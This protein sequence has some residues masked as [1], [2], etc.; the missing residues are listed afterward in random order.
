MSS[1]SINKKGIVDFLWDWADTNGDW[2][3][4]LVHKI[5]KSEQP[6]NSDERQE[7]F[8]YFLQSVNLKYGMQSLQITKPTY[9]PVGKNIKLKSL[10]NISGVNKLA[11][12]QTLHFGPNITI[13][14]GENGSG[15]TGYSRILRSLGYSYDPGVEILPNVHGTKEEKKADVDFEVDGVVKN[16]IW[17]GTTTDPGLQNLSVF[18]SHCVHFSLS[19]RRLIVSPVG[20]HLFNLVS[21]ELQELQRLFD[22]KKNSYSVDLPWAQNLNAGTPQQ[23]FINTLHARSSEANLVSISS[24]NPSDQQALD[25][26]ISG[27]QSLNKTLL[28]SE[29][30]S[31]NSQRI[32]LENL[33]NTINK[34]SEK[35]TKENWELHKDCINEIKELEKQARLGLTEIAIFQGISLYESSQFRSFIQAAENYIRIL[36]RPDYPSEADKCVYCLQPLDAVAKKLL[37]DYRALMNDKVGEALEQEKKRRAAGIEIFNAAKVLLNVHQTTFGQNLEGVA[38]QPPEILEYNKLVEQ[39]KARFINDDLVKSQWEGLDFELYKKF[40]MQKKN[41]LDEIITDKKK[42]LES[43]GQQEQALRLKIAELT[44]RKLLSSKIE[45]I[46]TAITNHKII[47]IFKDHS[48]AFITTAISRKT[49]EARDALMIQD[50]NDIFQKELKALRKS[51]IKVNLQFGT[52]RGHSKITQRIKTYELAQIL[53]EGEQKAIALAEFLTEI[54]LDNVKAP[55]IFDDPVNSLDHRIIDESVKRLIVLSE[56]RQVIIFTH[57]V[58]FM[59]SMKQQE[60]LPVKKHLNFSYRIVQQN[61]GQTGLLGDFHGLND[62]KYYLSKLNILLNSGTAGKDEGQMSAEGYGHLRSAIEVFVE[63][64]LLGYVVRRYRKGVAFPSLMRLSGDKINA[65]K[66]PLNDIY[67]KCC[68][69]IDGHSSPQELHTTPTIAELK[70]DFKAFDDIRAAFNKK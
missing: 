56:T 37:S 42:S 1:T 52:D 39:L 30:S 15:K 65:F 13:I 22:V 57:C 25:A 11:K 38:I 8:D 23:I 44:D 68:V 66:K 29:I 32:E 48:S 60:E 46:K 70:M 3:K 12:N 5:V 21:A 53:S 33:I 7:V 4:N 64:S 20:F 62:L 17:S 54:Q 41:K 51:D 16:F 55:V 40:L 2:A 43:L 28:S 24:F 6:L 27:L 50:F 19:D 58:L 69:S 26:A 36:D 18:N 59:N 45:D 14:F 10:S 35:F 34:A 9:T 63:E 67:E 49:T 47:Q 31:M 61:F